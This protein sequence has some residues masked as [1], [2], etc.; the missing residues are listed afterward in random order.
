MAT[1]SEV[2]LTGNLE[3]K[4][5]TGIDDE[6]DFKVVGLPENLAQQVMRDAP[7]TGEVYSAAR[8]TDWLEQEEKRVPE[9]S[10]VQKFAGEEAHLDRANA[11][12]T[13]TM[14]FK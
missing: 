11:T 13:V 3:V 2:S 8:I 9:A 5:W 12:A 1:D 6:N 14:L 10:M 7:K 4:H